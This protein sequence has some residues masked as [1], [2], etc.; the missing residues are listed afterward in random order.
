M[1]LIVENTYL[2]IRSLFQFKCNTIELEFAWQKNANGI[3]VNTRWGTPKKPELSSGGQAPRSTAFP[4]WVSV[5]GHVHQCTSWWWCEMMCFLP[6]N[7]RL[8]TKHLIFSYRISLIWQIR[9][10]GRPSLAHFTNQSIFNYELG[11]FNVLSEVVSPGAEGSV[12]GE[13]FCSPGVHSVAVH[14]GFYP[15]RSPSALDGVEHLQE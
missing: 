4:C 5:L 7:Y 14:L 6:W 8:N 15:Y 9:W 2:Q 10:S 13:G 1:P 11:I 3:E 12:C